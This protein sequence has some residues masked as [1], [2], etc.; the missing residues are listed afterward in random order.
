MIHA[1]D[2]LRQLT[3]GAVAALLVATLVLVVVRGLDEAPT[4]SAGPPNADEAGD[5]GEADGA[6]PSD[7]T[8]PGDAADGGPGPRGTAEGG[9]DLVLVS[10][11]VALS[12]TDHTGPTSPTTTPSG[13]SVPSTPVTTAP[14]PTTPGTPPAPPT[15]P[16]VTPPTTPGTTTPTPPPTPTPSP[17]KPAV[18]DVAVLS[19]GQLL[20]V[21]VNL[22]APNLVNLSVLQ[23]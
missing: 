21:D 1:L 2:R 6:R 10:Q 13:P 16:P 20:A 7:P 22:G 8:R 15:S 12:P 17:A 18:V 11:D 14:R 23:P 4:T 3:I 19:G 9:S 5:R